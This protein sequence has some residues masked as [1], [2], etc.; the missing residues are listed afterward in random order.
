MRGIYSS[1]F[2]KGVWKMGIRA[3]SDEKGIVR[4]EERVRC[5]K[6]LIEDEGGEEKRASF[7]TWKRLAREA[8][9]AG[10]TSDQNIEEFVSSIV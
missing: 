2:T 3:G 9:D 4:Q 7:E 5:V 1:H 8:V 6:Q 10:G